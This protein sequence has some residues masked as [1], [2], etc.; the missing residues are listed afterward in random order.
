MRFTN[1]NE[2]E[3]QNAIRTLEEA[4]ANGVASASYPGGGTINYTSQG[5][6]KITL[7]SLYK[8]L[9][10]MQNNSVPRIRRVMYSSPSKGL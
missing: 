6:M 3:L 7:K 10:K 1:W 9:D 2:A 4:V 5:N 8:A